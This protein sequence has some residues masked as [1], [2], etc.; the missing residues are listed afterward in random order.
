MTID[1]IYIVVSVFVF[2]GVIIILV[3]LLSFISKKL[4]PDGE[5]NI[6]INDGK[7]ILKVSPGQ[8]LLSALTEK[9]IFIPSGCGGAGTC[10][11]CKCKVNKGGG[12]LLATEAG[13][14]DKTAKKEGMRLACQC[15]VRED[16]EITIPDEI[17]E[18]KKWE[19]TSM[20]LVKEK[21]K[22]VN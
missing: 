17:L 21:A 1:P 20:R 7:K 12:D 22:E 10:G 9:E 19:E 15:K 6:D 3:L 2:T 16:M 11:L 8:N 4:S 5:V 13:F 14:I 18:I